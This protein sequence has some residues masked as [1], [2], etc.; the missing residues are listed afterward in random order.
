MAIFDVNCELCLRSKQSLRQSREV[1]DED[2]PLDLILLDVVD[3]TCG[4]HKNSVLLK[5]AGGHE[6]F[7]FV[8]EK[9]PFI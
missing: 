4:N 6:L 9:H 5:G 1:T 7:D 2:L 3:L 8:S